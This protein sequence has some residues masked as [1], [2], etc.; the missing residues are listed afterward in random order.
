M[1]V[2]KPFSAGWHYSISKQ[3]PMNMSLCYYNDEINNCKQRKFTSRIRPLQA[4][5]V[6][7]GDAKL[8]GLPEAF[9]PMSASCQQRHP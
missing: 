1:D 8:K 2:L 4:K 5:T 3:Q 6:K 7:T 9:A